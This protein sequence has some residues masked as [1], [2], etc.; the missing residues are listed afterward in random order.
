VETLKTALSGMAFDSQASNAR[1]RALLSYFKSL[2]LILST[3]NKEKYS[4][5]ITPKGQTTDK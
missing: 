3:R 5:Q 1:R 2:N 4:I